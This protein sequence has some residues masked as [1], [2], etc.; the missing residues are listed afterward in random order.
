MYTF[1]QMD[2]FLSQKDLNNL[3]RESW[4]D[5]FVL[6]LWRILAMDSFLYYKKSPTAHVEKMLAPNSHLQALALKMLMPVERHFVQIS[7]ISLLPNHVFNTHGGE[8]HIYDK[9]LSWLYVYT[10]FTVFD[11]WFR[12][13]DKAE[14]F[15][16]L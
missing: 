10:S 7:Q 12:F 15:A 14:I 6:N 2:R 1:V 4:F 5:R 9:N 16:D 3:L 11:E 8:S 13:L